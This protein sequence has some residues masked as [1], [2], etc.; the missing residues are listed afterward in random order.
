MD[1]GNQRF[2]FLNAERINDGAIFLGDSKAFEPGGRIGLLRMV[3]IR[4]RSAA[5]SVAHV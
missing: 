4:T 5:D 2:R 3:A 1:G